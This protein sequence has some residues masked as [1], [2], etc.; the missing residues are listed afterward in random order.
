MAR[1]HAECVRM[2]E[3]FRRAGVP[4]WV[5]YYRRALPRFLTMRELRRSRRDRAADLGARP[6]DRRLATRRGRR[7]TGGSI[8]RTRARGCSSIWRPTAWTCS[9]SCSARSPRRAA[10]PLNTGGTYAAED[11]TSTAFQFGDAVERDRHVE[12]QRGARRPTRSTITGSRGTIVS[13]IFTDTDLVVST[14]RRRGALP[15]PQSAARPSAADPDHRR[16][17]ARPRRCH[18][19]ASR[20]ARVMG[21]GPLPRGL[22][23]ASSTRQSGYSRRN[24]LPQASASAGAHAPLTPPGAPKDTQHHVVSLAGSGIVY[25]PGDALGVCPRN[26]EPLVDAILARLGA[27]GDEP[28]TAGRPARCRSARRCSARIRSVD[29]EPRGCSRPAWRRARTCSGRCCRKGAEDQLKQYLQARDDVHD[30]L[31]VLNDA[32]AAQFTPEEFVGAAARAAAAPV[33]DRL[34][35]AACIPT[36][37]TCW[38]S[39]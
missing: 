29:A 21:H 18:R 39:R 19:P 27:T 6:G 25:R 7:R 33:L 13:P 32:P 11:V 22:L 28:V 16:R 14:R 2:V 31:D 35:P 10:L 15:D 37:R 3:A 5:A 20:R 36:K 24:P 23:P 12:F 1:T 8:R 17:T 4:L 9:I 38:C 34:E 30:V 26:L